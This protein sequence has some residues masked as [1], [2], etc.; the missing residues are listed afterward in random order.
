MKV[1][2]I[3]DN[4][5]PGKRWPVGAEI[6]KD[7]YYTIRGRHINPHGDNCVVLHEVKSRRFFRNGIERGYF[8]SRFTPITNISIFESIDREVFEGVRV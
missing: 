3:D 1:I 5:G 2:C 6:I 7:R 4:P 8:A